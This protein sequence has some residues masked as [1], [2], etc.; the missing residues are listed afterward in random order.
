LN[1]QASAPG[2]FNSRELRA[3][4]PWRRHAEGEP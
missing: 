4:L 3:F 2:S 1:P